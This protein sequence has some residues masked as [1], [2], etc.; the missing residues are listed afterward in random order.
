MPA[1]ENDFLEKHLDLQIYESDV[2]HEQQAA[3]LLL[4]IF[5]NCLIDP[6]QGR[7]VQLIMHARMLSKNVLF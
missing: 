3:H 5:H 4:W 6:V 1:I 7:K 2:V